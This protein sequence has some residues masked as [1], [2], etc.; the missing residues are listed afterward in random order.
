MFLFHL[1]NIFNRRATLFHKRA[2]RFQLNF[3]CKQNCNNYLK[4]A[5]EFLEHVLIFHTSSS[6]RIYSKDIVVAFL[7]LSTAVYKEL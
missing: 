1:I 2:T 6:A 4:N 3:F 5:F 7:N